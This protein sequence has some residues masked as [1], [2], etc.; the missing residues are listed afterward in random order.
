MQ[1]LIKI[2]KFINVEY[3]ELKTE[4]AG[5]KFIS[6]SVKLKFGWLTQ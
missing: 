1:K 5:H 3:H 2:T 4:S 6:V